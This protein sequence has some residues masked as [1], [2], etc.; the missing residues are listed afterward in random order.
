MAVALLWIAAE[1]SSRSP[2]ASSNPSTPIVVTQTKA[3]FYQVNSLDEDIEF[4]VEA[5]GTG[6][7]RDALHSENTISIHHGEVRVTEANCANQVCVEHTAIH[8]PGE[9]IVCLPHG[10]VVQ[11]A[12]NEADIAKLSSTQNN[13]PE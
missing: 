4:T 5:P 8:E 7:G 13:K 10:L 12:N 6:S 9:Q 1:K 3:G 11:I 2:S